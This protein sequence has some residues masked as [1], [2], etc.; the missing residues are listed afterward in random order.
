MGDEEKLDENFQLL[1][2]TSDSSLPAFL[3]KDRALVTDSRGV[4]SRGAE[5][6]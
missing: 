2:T 3:Q 1:H 5:R 4:D 6:R